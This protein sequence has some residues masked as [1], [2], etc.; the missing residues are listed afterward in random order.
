MDTRNFQT[1]LLGLEVKKNTEDFESVSVNIISNHLIK[2]K[3]LMNISKYFVY[4][5]E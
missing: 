2:H 4:L 3:K 1:N 5:P